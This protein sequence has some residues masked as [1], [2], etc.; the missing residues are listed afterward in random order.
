M[1]MKLLM[2]YNSELVLNV[3]TSPAKPRLCR[4]LQQHGRPEDDGVQWLR[5]G[6]GAVVRAPVLN[7]H[8]EVH[9]LLCAEGLLP[10]RAAGQL[11]VLLSLP[12]AGTRGVLV[13]LQNGVLCAFSSLRG[14]GLG[15]VA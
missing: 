5:H 9:R 10:R 11:P 15:I 1:L 8:R 3:S 13:G 2:K 14:D 6:R 7:D 12:G 4:L